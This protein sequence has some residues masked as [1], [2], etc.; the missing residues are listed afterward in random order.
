MDDKSN[1]RFFADVDP[2]KGVQTTLVLGEVDLSQ[3]QAIVFAGGHG[4]MWD[5]SFDKSVK[6]SI[7]SVYD[8]GGVVA[9]VCH[10]PAAL[11]DVKLTDGSYIVAAKKIAVFTDE[12]ERIVQL[13]KK[14][15][16]CSSPN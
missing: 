3:Y 5:F 12:E 6:S 7:A 14:C 8:A 15:R 2:L 11:V 1:Q 10:G 9:A 4:T 13:E 16:T